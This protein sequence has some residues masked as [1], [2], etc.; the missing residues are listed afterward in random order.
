MSLNLEEIK[1]TRK[2]LLEEI[3]QEFIDELIPAKIVPDED[4]GMPVLSILFDDL[5]AEGLENLGEFFFMPTINPDEDM[6]IFTNIITILE[7]MDDGRLPELAMAIAIL[8]GLIPIGSFAIDAADG[9]L[10]YRHSYE[11]PIS[12]EKETLKDCVELAMG[13]AADT[14]SK[15]AYMLVEV[16]EGERSAASVFDYFIAGE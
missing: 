2:Q 15:F 3:E 11:M 6:Q 4:I 9:T 13:A 8:N 5:A 16:N 10:I 1:E 7:E 12:F 14:V